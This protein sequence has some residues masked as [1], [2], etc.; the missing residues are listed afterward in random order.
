VAALAMPALSAGLVLGRD[1]Q[2]SVVVVRL[3]RPQP[4]RVTL[5]G[6]W[7]AGRLVAA[8]A[9]ALGARVVVSTVNPGQWQGFGE[10][11]TGREDRVTVIG[12]EGPVPPAG[13]ATEPV[14]QIVD[15]GPSGPQTRPELAAWQS[16]LTLLT[17]LTDAGIPAVENADL[18]IVQRLTEPEARAAIRAM[19]LAPEAA[20]HLQMLADDMLAIVGGG[21]DRYLWVSQTPTEHA[22]LGPPRRG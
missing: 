20:G 17:E 11:M 2:R 19:R 5:V 16:Q 3:L 7:W 10:A 21:A 8:R 22:Q 1:Q 12:G 6:G 18:V 13:S 14:L 4:T 15:I 9:L